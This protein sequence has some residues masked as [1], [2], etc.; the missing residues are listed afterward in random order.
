M[1]QQGYCSLAIGFLWVLFLTGCPDNRPSTPG[2]SG[3]TGPEPSGPVEV[4]G[5]GKPSKDVG[6]MVKFPS[7]SFRLGSIDFEDERSGRV[8]VLS[9]FSL[10]SKEVSNGEYRLFLEDLEKNGMPK[11]YPKFLLRRFP[12]GKDHRPRHW[13][14]DKY[15]AVSSSERAP[16]VWVDWFDATAYAAWAGKRLPTECEW[17]RAA[18]WNTKSRR[19]RM[20][21]WG[22]RAPDAKGVY[23]ANFKPL[24]GA[25]LD[26][27]EGLA[28]VDA[29]PQG[30]T[31][32]GLLNMGGNVAE[33]CSDWYFPSY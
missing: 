17:E 32:E 20:Y 33:W 5:K 24:L 14:T 1:K 21:P 2:K 11:S 30:A 4:Q 23:L 16:V 15:K 28:L 3:A 18:G 7:G 12:K 27:Y 13:G 10:D 26:G 25:G 6:D 31:P 9:E 8:V 22:D 19:K 29:F